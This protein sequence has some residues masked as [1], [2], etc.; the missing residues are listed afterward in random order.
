MSVG[1]MNFPTEQ[2]SR[3]VGA[4]PLLLWAFIV[5][6]GQVFFS[7]LFFLFLKMKCKSQTKRN[8]SAFQ[9]KRLKK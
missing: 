6:G 8:A 7:L 9:L 4:L 3:D 5:K 2:S 1:E